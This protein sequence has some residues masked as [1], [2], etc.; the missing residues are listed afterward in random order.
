MSTKRLKV[1]PFLMKLQFEY[2]YTERKI[3]NSMR[4]ILQSWQ[5]KLQKECKS[6]HLYTFRSSK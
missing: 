3:F 5:L 2:C 4:Y 6:A 1:L